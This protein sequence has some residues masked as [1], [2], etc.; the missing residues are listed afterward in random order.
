MNHKI[1]CINEEEHPSHP[2][3][4]SHPLCAQ[5]DQMEKMGVKDDR[6]GGVRVRA[7]AAGLQLK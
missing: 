2:Y 5:R 4:H 6:M 7:V 1:K 3:Q